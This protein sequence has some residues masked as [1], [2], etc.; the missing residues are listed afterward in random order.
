MRSIKTTF[1]GGEFGDALDGRVDLQKYATAARLL[2]NCV[3]TRYG[4][5]ESRPGTKFV[6][7]TRTTGDIKFIPFEFNISQTYILE[8]TDYAMRVV[9]DGGIIQTSYRTAS[10]QW[11]ASGSGTGEYYL[12]TSASADPTIADALQ[13][14]SVYES[15]SKMDLGAL[16]SLAVSEFGIGDNDA[17]GYTTLYVRLSDGTD[18]D[19]KAVDYLKADYV[20]ETPYPES[21]LSVLDYAQSADTI[22]MANQDYAPQTLQR[23]AED[24]WTIAATSFTPSITAPIDIDVELTNFSATD[25]DVLYAVSS[26]TEDLEESL[27]SANQKVA[28]D[29]NWPTTARVD[30]YWN[31]IRSSTFKWTSSPAAANEFYLEVA[32]GGDPSIDEPTKLYEDKT[33]M[34]AGTIGSLAIGEWAYGDNDTLGYSTIY[35]RIAG[36]ADPDTKAVGYLTYKAT[37]ED[38]YAI[39]KNYYGDW[40]WLG[41]VEDPWY[42][43]DFQETNV[44]IS[45]K[46]FVNLF[47]AVD[48]YPGVVGIFEQRLFY[49]RTNNE[50]QK[51]WSSYSGHLNNFGKSKPLTAADPIEVRLISGG[52]IDEIRHLTTLEKMVMFTAGSE[53]LF[54]RGNNSDAITPTTVAFN[55]IGYDGTIKDIKPIRIGNSALYVRRNS[56]DIMTLSPADVVRY[57][58]NEV[59]LLVPHLLEDRT[60][61]DWAYQQ[62]PGNVVWMIMDDGYPISLTFLPEQEIYAFARHA[63]DGLYKAVGSVTSD[64]ED[65]LYFCVERVIEGSTVRFI[66]QAASREFEFIEDAYC[67][68]AGLSYNEP[69]T[70]TGVT[71]S[72]SA[73]TVTSTGHS[74]V[75]DEYVRLR[76]VEGIEPAD[77]ANSDYPEFNGKYYIV[78]NAAANTFTLNDLDGGALTSSDF[79][80]SYVRGGQARKCVLN[81]SNLDHLEGEVVDVLADGNVLSKTVS[82][83][84]ITLKDAQPG[85]SV[86]HAGLGYDVNIQT[87]RLDEQ[88]SDGTM[89]GEAKRI[90]N[91]TLRVKDTSGGYL[92]T[93]EDNLTYI[94]WRQNEDW[95]EANRVKTADIKHTVDGTWDTEGQVYYRQSDP[96]P[97][98]VLAMVMHFDRGGKS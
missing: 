25:R 46:S 88:L 73:V 8:F 4:G 36:S 18:P 59:S 48:D 98:T 80:G 96:L 45:P 54:G 56:R 9:K 91:V 53:W 78:D 21:A 17:L 12:Q 97:T 77:P 5:V 10:Y 81:I 30:L 58:A 75:D 28:L 23:L 95:L 26:I 34:T 90:K 40:G 19:S 67:V 27:P 57:N 29:L 69:K 49:A 2:E 6:D 63:T 11:I 79:T 35:V 74:L 55:P 44:S 16:G 71:I 65:E 72:G 93:D 22:F 84:S 1:A 92:G 41:T 14:F 24:S 43:D 37:D 31:S 87:L 66:E 82:S 39:Y 50:P 61:I 7:Y 20:L 15:G 70:I 64:G 60:I 33:A 86:V 13:Y 68:D 47:D 76:G 32:A 42:L 62:H 3:V 85:Y 89:Q 52:R 51:V 94:K 83:G 38:Q